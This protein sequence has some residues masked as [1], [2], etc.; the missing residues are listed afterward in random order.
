MIHGLHRTFRDAKE[1]HRLSSAWRCFFAGA[2]AMFLGGC[3]YDKV[4][5]D[6]PED[7]DRLL[8]DFQYDFEKRT[9]AYI[10]DISETLSSKELADE[11]WV[12]GILTTREYNSS[13]NVIYANPA[14]TFFSYRAEGSFYT[15]GAHGS[16]A[17]YLGTIDVATGRKL[18]VADVIPVPQR[19]AALDQV[20]K[21]VI[22][23]LNGAEYVNGEITL[24]E[25]FCIC[26]DGMHFLFQEYEIA[27]YCF[28][29]VEVVVPA[30]GKYRRNDAQRRS[31]R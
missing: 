18:Q 8:W 27:A 23:K 14:R 29:P 12:G 5:K 2:I 6:E 22:N 3:T 31:T 4:A 7:S 30:Y 16:S 1:M 20:K 13:Y 28:G 19:K 17:I 24:T 9:E 10:H 21:A 25:N 11:V 15:G 26:E